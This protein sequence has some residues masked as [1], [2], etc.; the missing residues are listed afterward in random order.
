MSVNLRWSPPVFIGNSPVLGYQV[1][2]RAVDTQALPQLISPVGFG[3]YTTN[4]TRFN[5]T[6]NIIPYTRYEYAIEACN[7]IGCSDRF[8]YSVFRTDPAGENRGSSH[9]IKESLIS[10]QH[11]V[12]LHA[13]AK[14]QPFL[15]L[16][17]VCHGMFLSPL[18][19]SSSTIQSHLSQCSH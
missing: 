13:T 7:A 4:S 11:L 6:S 17:L 18:T 3:Q 12:L 15:P 10:S 14:L 2:Q 5:I 19:D 16:L 1:Y 9:T 8:V